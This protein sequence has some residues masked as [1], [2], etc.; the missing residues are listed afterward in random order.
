[1]SYLK[2]NFS[3][4]KFD[5][6]KKIADFNGIASINDDESMMTE[7]DILD[8]DKVKILFAINEEEDISRDKVN[9][10]ETL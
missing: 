2:H 8:Y 3:K 7:E 5:E 4:I 6:E 9:V 1:M 10:M